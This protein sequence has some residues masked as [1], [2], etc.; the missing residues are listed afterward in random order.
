MDEERI[1]LRWLVERQREQARNRLGRSNPRTA[2]PHELRAA[3]APIARSAE[4]AHTRPL[5][6]SQERGRRLEGPAPSSRPA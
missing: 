1:I 2:E 5:G 3:N 6:V 4:D